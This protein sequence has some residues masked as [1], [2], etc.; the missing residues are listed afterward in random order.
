MQQQ[1]LSAASPP[2]LSL[3]CHPSQ[4]ARQGTKEHVGVGGRDTRQQTVHS[5]GLFGAIFQ[6]YKSEQSWSC[7][8]KSDTL[9]GSPQNWWATITL[10]PISA[11]SELIYCTKHL[12]VYHRLIK[13]ALSPDQPCNI[14]FFASRKE[15]CLPK[16][17][18]SLDRVRLL[19][20][21][22]HG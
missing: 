15:P 22:S 5:S 1:E 19:R 8:N 17:P 18:A 20:V 21:L 2:S 9:C 14:V 4:E 3:P 13:G 10:F 16:G 7:C 12:L 11:F 6:G